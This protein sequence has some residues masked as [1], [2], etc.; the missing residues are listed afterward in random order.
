MLLQSAGFQ[1]IDVSS[2]EQLRSIES[3][4]EVVV[5]CHTLPSAACKEALTIVQRRWP[6]AKELTLA[7][8]GGKND[9]AEHSDE[10]FSTV[11][12]P[13]RLIARVRELVPVYPAFAA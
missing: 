7:P 9:C 6:H 1:V 13:A 5:L 2:L 8:L 12:G 11:E 4:I 3:P 10:S